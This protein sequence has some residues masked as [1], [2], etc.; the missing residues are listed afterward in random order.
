MKH[1]GRITRSSEGFTLI[2][3]LISISILTV[4][5]GIFGAGMFQVLSIQRFWTDD[6]RATREIRH[7]G[8]WIAGDALN[9]TDVFD[10][11]GSARLTCTPSPPVEQV[12]L[13]WTEFGGTTQIAT[14]S[15]SGDELL[16][17]N[18]IELPLRM[19]SRVVADTLTF[20]LCGSSFRVI[21]DVYSDRG[22]TER[23]DLIT[24]LRHLN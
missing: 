11:G 19:A 10:A 24:N 8:S 16:R 4:V 23:L 12:T 7:A 17:D 9:A 5:T 6:I 1:V 13:T 14:Y 21:M 20:T 2:E 15:I 18:G 22:T 3:L